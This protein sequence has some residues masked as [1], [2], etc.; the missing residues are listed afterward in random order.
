MSFLKALK[1]NKP[2][3]SLEGYFMTILAPSKFGKTT[4]AI[5]LAD[6]FY[7]GLDKTLLLATEIGY[8]TMNGV[9]ALN[10]TG[11]DYAENDENENE[12]GFIETID[13]LIENKD[14][15]PFR[16][17]IIDT[18]TALERYAVAYAIRKANRDDNPT[19][20]YSDISDIPWGKGYTMVA[21]VIYS[22]IDRLKKAGFGVLIIGHSKTKK[23]TNKDGFEYDYTT[24]NVLGKTSDIIEREADMII[25]GDLMVEE[26]EDGKAT[27]SRKL[28]F[29]SDGNI[30]CG[31]RFRNFPAV[32]DNDVTTFLSTFED[33]VLGLYEGDKK[34]VKKAEKEQKAETDKKSENAVKKAEE[35]DKEAKAIE[36]VKSEIADALDKLEKSGKLK[37][38]KY[39]KEKL[40]NKG[41]YRKSEDLEGL[42]DALEFTKSV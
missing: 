26:G 15:H 36:E 20:R 41:D 6:E 32:I 14:E 1:P 29:R 25:Y 8:K 5:D 27:E 37:C 23:I 24:L 7:K 17:I 12:K 21:E 28:R 38:A 4:F 9:F 3:V 2:T 42:K 34:A 10:I 30:L 18:I 39:Y 11:F 40:G 33:A 31:T 16:F 13:E 19:K 22:Q 35:V